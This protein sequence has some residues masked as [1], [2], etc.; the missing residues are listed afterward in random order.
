MQADI[1]KLAV[2]VAHVEAQI[3]DLQQRMARVEGLV[4]GLRPYIASVSVEDAEL[5]SE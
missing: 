2:Q 1:G 4:E 3:A 5:S